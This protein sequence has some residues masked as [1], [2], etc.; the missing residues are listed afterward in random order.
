MFLTKDE[1]IGLTGCKQTHKQVKWLN[2]RAYKY[3]ISAIGKPIVLK[4]HIEERLS[5]SE[6]KNKRSQEPDFSRLVLR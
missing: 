2:Q 1:I 4:A 6:H 5:G 3:D